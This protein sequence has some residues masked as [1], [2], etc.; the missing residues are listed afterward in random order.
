MPHI[1]DAV[2]S[3]GGLFEILYIFGSL[4]DLILFDPIEDLNFL[5]HWNESKE[6]E[7]NESFFKDYFILQLKRMTSF[8]KCCEVGNESTDNLS[9]I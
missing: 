7:N 3:V 1:L 4:I 6:Q 2:S 5:H 8:V 9:K